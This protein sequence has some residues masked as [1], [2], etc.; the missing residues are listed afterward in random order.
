MDPIY[1]KEYTS[2]KYFVL[3][4]AEVNTT[5]CSDMVVFR[6]MGGVFAG[7]SIDL[8]FLGLDYFEMPNRLRGVRVWRPRDQYALQFGK[9]S[10][11]HYGEEL[12]DNVYAIESNGK[13]YHAVADNIW[14]HVHRELNRVSALTSF[15][16]LGERDEY[17]MLG[18][19]TRSNN[20]FRSFNPIHPSSRELLALTNRRM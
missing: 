18:N 12:G 20:I 17:A 14:V 15:N 11:P 3:Y 1:L 19:G 13:R 16:D 2:E 8:I 5:L 6:A 10:A 4:E 7:P 9:S